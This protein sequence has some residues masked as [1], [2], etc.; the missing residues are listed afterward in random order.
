MF[1][2]PEMMMSFER[3]LTS[4]V[5]V[6]MQHGEIAGV[7]PAAPECL[8]GRLRILQIALH[9]R[10]AA[11][12]QLADGLAIRRHRRHGFRI[13]DLSSSMVG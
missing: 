9:H 6:G 13:G 11:E 10:V 8:G 5:A 12:H 1:S 3:S 2:P 4:D 7:E